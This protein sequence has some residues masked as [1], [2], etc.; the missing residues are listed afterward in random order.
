MRLIGGDPQAHRI[1]KR[2][3]F[4]KAAVFSLREGGVDASFANHARK[5]CS[6]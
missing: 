2:L 6:A 1:R 3:P 4:E 5:T